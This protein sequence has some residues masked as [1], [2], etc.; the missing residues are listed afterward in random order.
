MII[1]KNT[2][3]N[4]KTLNISFPVEDQYYANDNE[5]IVADGITRDPIGILD[6]GTVSFEELVKRYPRPSGAELAAKAIVDEFINSEGTLRERLYK[7]NQAVKLLN[8]KYIPV[9]DYL[10]NDYFGAVA[11]CAKIE[12]DY[13]NYSFIC[14]CG[15]IVYDKEGNIKF[16]TE[17][18]MQLYSEPY[19]D[20][21]GYSWNLPEARVITRRKY[22]NKLDTKVNGVCVSYGAL[23]GEDNANYFIRSG[24]IRLDND[25]IVVV[26]SDGFKEYLYLEEFINL[27]NNFNQQEFEQYIAEKSYTDYD[28]YG[29]EKTLVIM[30]K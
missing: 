2:F 13:L 18:E 28:K 4:I 27:I 7:C 3:E 25:D 22:R 19:F 11:S 26:Y 5:A 8:D 16:Q 14:D 21:K 10:E 6:F 17:D 15:V 29:K 1:Y 12:D 9:C 24:K 20:R 30:K 23:T